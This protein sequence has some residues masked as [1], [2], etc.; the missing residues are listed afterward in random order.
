MLRIRDEPITIKGVDKLTLIGTDDN[1]NVY[2]GE[3]KDNLVSKIY[4][5][6]ISEDTINWKVVNLQIPT[7]KNDLFVSSVGK[8]YQNDAL[9]GVVK[10]INSGTETSYQGKL[11]QLYTKGVVSLVDNKI[12]FVPF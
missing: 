12:S 9:K 4:Y 8:I 1:D 11:L 3:L 7:E 10:D 5:G 6:K 2:L